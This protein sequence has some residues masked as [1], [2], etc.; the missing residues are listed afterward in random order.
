MSWEYSNRMEWFST[1]DFFQLCD[2]RFCF[3]VSKLLYS[4]PSFCFHYFLLNVLINTSVSKLRYSTKMNKTPPLPF[5]F[6]TITK[7]RKSKEILHCSRHENTQM[8]TLKNMQRVPSIYLKWGT[9]GKKMYL[10]PIIKPVRYL[11][12]IMII[13][14]GKNKWSI[15]EVVLDFPLYINF[16][17]SSVT[18]IYTFL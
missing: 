6:Q 4:V 11:F 3:L 12:S 1:K 8:I 17:C 10:F 13:F 2:H 9:M 16:N 7:N 15:N 18:G 14:P 5:R